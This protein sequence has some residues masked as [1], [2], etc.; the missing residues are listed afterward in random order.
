MIFVNRI[1]LKNHNKFTPYG[2]SYFNHRHVLC[3]ETTDDEKRSVIINMQ[4]QLVS[5]K[6]Y[7]Y[8][9]TSSKSPSATKSVKYVKTIWLG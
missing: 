7:R 3:K 4:Q 2:L 6:N 1:I 5:Y 8:S 9:T